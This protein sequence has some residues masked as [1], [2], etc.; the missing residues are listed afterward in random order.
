YQRGMDIGVLTDGDF[1]SIELIELQGQD[2]RHELIAMGLNH[3]SGKKRW[4][5]VNQTRLIR[6]LL[7]EC[8]M[9]EN[10]VCNAL[11]I[12]KY[13][14]RRSMRTLAL[15][16]RYKNSDYGDQFQTDKYSIFEE[17]IKNTV[18]K[19]WLGWN[20]EQR[21]STRLDREER[22]FSWI[23]V[24]ER[25]IRDEETGD[26]QISKLEPI[27]TKSHE[28]REL[29]KFVEDE[30]A[31]SQM[32]ESRSVTIGFASSEAVGETRLHNALGNIDSEVNAALRFSDFL[33][34][35][36]Y[37]RIGRLKTKL[38][39]LLPSSNDGGIGSLGSNVAPRFSK[40][41]EHYSTLYIRKYRKIAGLKISK[42][43]RLNLFVGENN[44]GKTSLL[45]AVYLLAQLNDMNAFLDLER[46][47]GKFFKD[48]NALW[49][50]KNFISLIDIAGCFNGLETQVRI[51]KEETREN[52][53]RIAYI[54][55]IR[56]DANAGTDD[57]A[58]YVHLYL[59]REPELYYQKAQKLCRSA[60]SSPYR[61]N[62]SLLREA[63]T[64]AVKE[65]RIGEIIDFIRQHID[66]DIEKIE[67]LDI[68]GENRFFV[69]SKV[70]DS[71]IDLTK[72]GEGL[73][74]IF[75]IALL[76]SYCS[77]GILCIDEIDSAIH[78]GL[79]IR[80]AEFVQK[81]A[82]KYNVQ[83]F[84]TT[85]SKECV[86]A[87]SRTQN[88]DLMAFALQNTPSNAVDFRYLEGEELKELIDIIDIDIR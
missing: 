54:S 1:K 49:V 46:F 41:S 21:A 33:S 9:T 69:T 86:D 52:I 43:R 20:D 68:H 25:V 14:L 4:S 65:K 82:A 80:F 75:E 30:K 19:N 84:L 88:E 71:S 7:E 12:T 35:D 40:L 73:Q 39:R 72:Y 60:F 57:L 27:V 42:L 87:F 74:R 66:P 28:I 6:D 34:D 22:L 77:D 5:P 62:D 50:D 29:A 83:L 11:G 48:F 10:E 53:D 8:R 3:I 76:L 51:S 37:I 45:E 56:V 70:H 31:V 61:Y 63:H 47:R 38:E 79:L 18:L 55:T 81:L 32:E 13:Y 36:D 44:S 67:L 2:R 16:E 17:I 59:N 58:S 26:E 64:R 85:H 78:K 23:S 15:I 24:T